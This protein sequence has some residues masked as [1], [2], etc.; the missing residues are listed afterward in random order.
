MITLQRKIEYILQGS[1]PHNFAEIEELIQGITTVLNRYNNILPLLAYYAKV[2]YFGDSKGD[3]NKWLDWGF[4]KLKL[5]KAS[6]YKYN[7]IGEF[8]VKLQET[9][10]DFFNTL[11]NQPTSKV[12]MLHSLNNSQLED[13]LGKYD[14]NDLTR[15][16]V[17]DIVN[18]NYLLSSEEAFKKPVKLKNKNKEEVKKMGL[19]DGIRLVEEFANLKDNDF[20][21]T[22]EMISVI[23]PNAFAPKVISRSTRQILAIAP[24]VKKDDCEG[25]INDLMLAVDLLRAQQES[26][27]NN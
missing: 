20:E 9:N 24:K 13:F 7:T 2:D 22:L 27:N 11:I 6:M 21:A 26:P 16:D 17:Q 12:Y 3:I 19:E 23:L 18:N 4:E 1:K 5:A 14:L 8:L 25:L 10:M 15:D